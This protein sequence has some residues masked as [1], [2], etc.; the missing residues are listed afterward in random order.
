MLLSVRVVS[1][2]LHSPFIQICQVNK[3]FGRFTALPT[4]GGWWWCQICEERIPTVPE[5]VEELYVSSFDDFFNSLFD[6]TIFHFIVAGTT[7][8]PIF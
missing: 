6:F 7:S 4:A 3:F 5:V 8:A 1:S 2:T